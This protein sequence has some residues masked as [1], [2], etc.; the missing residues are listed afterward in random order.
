MKLQVL[1][2]DIEADLLLSASTDF[3]VFDN[4]IKNSNIFGN[5]IYS[6]DNTHTNRYLRSL[7]D[8]EKKDALLNPKK[9]LL[10]VECDG[11]EYDFEQL[12]DYE[13]NDFYISVDD[14]YSML[15]YY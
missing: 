15:I 14:E 7:S 9:Y 8:Y 4:N 10:N 12:F 11:D 2:S 13:Y 3:S 5:I 6:C 1:G